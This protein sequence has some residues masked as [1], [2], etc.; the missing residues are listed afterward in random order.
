ML[1]KLLCRFLFVA[2]A[3]SAVVALSLTGIVAA[4]DSAHK[5]N[6]RVEDSAETDCKTDCLVVG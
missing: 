3:Y 5:Q 4:V 6:N 2:S 1:V